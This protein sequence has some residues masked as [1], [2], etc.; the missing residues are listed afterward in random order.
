VRVEK[1]R[2]LK[3]TFRTL[4]EVLG[5]PEWP[6]GGW[7]DG[8]KRTAGSVQSAYPNSGKRGHAS[9]FSGSRQRAAGGFGYGRRL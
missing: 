7:A 9:L 6:A 8:W 5:H 4:A 3:S 2:S 1:T